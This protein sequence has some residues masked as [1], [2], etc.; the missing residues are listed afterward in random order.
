MSEAFLNSA[1]LA[2]SGGFQDAYTYNARN[3]VFCNAQTG[4]VVLM[5]QHFMAG[6]VTAGL[7]YFFPIIFFALGVWVAEKIQAN[8][9]YAQKLHWRQG[10]LLAEI[11]ILF[12]VGFLPTEYNMLANAMASFACAMQ[13]QSFR[14]VNGYSYASTMCIGNLRSGTAA[15]SVYFREKKSKQLKQAMYYFG[16]ILMFALGAGI[17]GNLSIRYGIRMIWV[18]CGFLMISF[19]LMFIEKYKHFHEEHE[20]K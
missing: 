18:S 4:N 16:I 3:E 19:L 15:L 10:V 13:V 11:L 5:S 17:G 9:K 2:L 6:E 12:T 14:K 7:G 8:Y 20:I 1:F